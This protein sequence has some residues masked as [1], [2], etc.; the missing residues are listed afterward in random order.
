VAAVIAA[1]AAAFL[2]GAVALFREHRAQQRRLLVAARATESSFRVASNSIKTS[3]GSGGWQ[4]F[5]QLPGR[6]SFAESW[7]S[8]KAD[9]AG[10]LT[11]G[12][13]LQVETA[14]NT[15][16][17]VGVMAQDEAPRESEGVLTAAQEKLESGT[18]VLRPYCERR[19]SLWKLL[20]RRLK[21]IVRRLRN[22]SSRDRGGN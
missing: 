16:L 10:H 5:N 18:R 14:V 22:H 20:K 7:D 21:T 3:L 15:Y 1:I 8:Y 19:L 12:E 11:W 17:A 6:S 2:A 9:L 13:W 4:P